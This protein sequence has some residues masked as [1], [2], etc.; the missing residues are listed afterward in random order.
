MPDDSIMTVEVVDEVRCFI[1]FRTTYGE[2]VLIRIKER[3][4]EEVR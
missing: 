3:Y 2:L 1:A 4:K